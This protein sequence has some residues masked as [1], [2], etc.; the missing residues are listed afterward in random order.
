MTK[1]QLKLLDFILPKLSEIYPNSA[2]LSSLVREYNKQ[3]DTVHQPPII[4]TDLV[5]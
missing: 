3:T 4:W 1:K 2:S 5:S